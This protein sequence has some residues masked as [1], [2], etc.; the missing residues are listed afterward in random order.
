MKR[1]FCALVVCVIL[2]PVVFTGCRHPLEPDGDL[3]VTSYGYDF[4]KIFETFWRGMDRNYA[5]WSEE[6][7]S[8]W[9]EGVPGQ[10]I[11]GALPAQTRAHI[12]KYPESF[13]DMIYDEYKPKF[14]ELGVFLINGEHFKDPRYIHAAN[15]AL[16]YF[17]EMTYGLVDGHF[18]VQFN[19]DALAAFDPG[20]ILYNPNYNP[21]A[22]LWPQGPG[23]LFP[24][25]IRLS[26]HYSADD[27]P[28]A[29]S[30]FFLSGLSEPVAKQGGTPITDFPV[31]LHPAILHP[32]NYFFTY[33]Y[34]E[35][36]IAK[37]FSTPVNVSTRQNALSALTFQ[38]IPLKIAKGR[39]PISASAGGGDIAYLLFNITFLSD[40]SP[41]V[42]G[43][44]LAAAKGLIDS[45]LNDD[46]YDSNVKGLII[47]VRGNT[48]GRQ[49]DYGYIL[50]RL[51]DEPLTFGHSRAKAGNGR[52]DYTPWAPIRLMP[53]PPDP[54][55]A[56][57]DKN[58]P[59][60]LLVNK[61][62]FSSAEFMT[63]AVKA[64]PNGTVVGERTNGASSDT[65]DFFTDNGGGFFGGNF[66]TQAGGS[67]VQFRTIDGIVNE[68]KGMM[69]DVE[70]PMTREDW[71][72]FYGLG[73]RTPRDRQLEAAIKV[74]DPSRTF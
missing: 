55:R 2:L 35:N 68:G 41:M 38:G 59:V 40:H 9:F 61:G 3:L 73:G 34:V 5:F 47:D 72:D 69:P 6:P 60:V 48:G 30:A 50:G 70:V 54:R 4:P 62:T 43:A 19:M 67:V 12:N 29:K 58:I 56:G 36:T 15:K 65:R 27:P 13:W 37:Y 17:F 45:F 7:S 23:N 16:D 32:D 33:N 51:I 20:L 25:Q 42:G 28:W 63:M 31:D 74:I 46:F 44:D 8:L 22:R 39:I 53:A 1:F 24:G 64:L 52:L 71:K 18:A 57:A 10:F 49:E 14:D 26:L 21:L 11:F 66:Q